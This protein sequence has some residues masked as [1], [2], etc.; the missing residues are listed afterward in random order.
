MINKIYKRYIYLYHAMVSIDDG[1]DYFF[2]ILI[3][4]V[5]MG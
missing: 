1:I 4:L 5:A 2:E 3:F